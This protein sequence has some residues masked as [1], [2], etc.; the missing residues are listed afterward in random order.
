MLLD[1]GEATL[2]LNVEDDFL[3]IPMLLGAPQ[4]KS[5]SLMIFINTL[6]SLSN[7]V[8]SQ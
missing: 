8:F 5:K 7:D 1:S 2:P 3:L 6:E 4:P